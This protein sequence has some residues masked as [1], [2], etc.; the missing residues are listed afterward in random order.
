MTWGP[1]TGSPTSGERIE[2]ELL[3][4]PLA[5]RARLAERLTASLDE[6]SEI[7]AAWMAEV[8]RR[9]AVLMSRAKEAIPLEDALSSVHAKS[10]LVAR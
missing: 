6:G 3:K 8:R 4:L 10:T 7:E 1:P 5:E 9:N 2:Q